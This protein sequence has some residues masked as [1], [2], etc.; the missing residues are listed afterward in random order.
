MGKMY[1][2]GRQIQ[3][4]EAISVKVSIII[5][6]FNVER[7]IS[8]AIQSCLN[9]IYQD[10]EIICVDNNSTD[11]TVQIIK[12]Y[13]SKFPNKIQLLFEPKQGAAYARNLGLVKSN[14][15]WIQFLDADDILKPEKIDSNLMLV[16]KENADF[17]V[18]SWEYLQIDGVLTK[19]PATNG[20][21]MKSIFVG[22]HCGNTCANFWKKRALLDVE[23]FSEIPDCHDPDLMIK[24]L[25][26]NKKYISDDKFYTIVRRRPE[27]GQIS[28]SNLIDH[29]LRHCQ[30]RIETIAKLKQYNRNYFDANFLFLYAATIFYYRKAYL[31]DNVKA[32]DHYQNYFHYS[33]QLVYHKEIPLSKL[34]VM[35]F[36]ILG[37][38][39]VEFVI[40]LKKYF[41]KKLIFL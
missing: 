5:P 3:T 13:I 27:G 9:Q 36:N 6:T 22:R 10:I 38:K 8:E 30:M 41:T 20:S 23:G 12:L 1:R 17:L 34:Y 19:I 24:L 11:N 15:Q 40:R 2:K 28:L 7:Y 26:K 18:G 39:G 14:G 37:F 29:Y 33:A 25:L 31:E 4:M 21:L 35:L 32:L 16:L